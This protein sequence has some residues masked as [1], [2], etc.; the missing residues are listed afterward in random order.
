GRLLWCGTHH[1]T[2]PGHSLLDE[3]HR[4]QRQRLHLDPRQVH[5]LASM[6]DVNTDKTPGLIKVQHDSRA[7]L[8]GLDTRPIRKVYVE[9]VGL[10]IVVESHRCS[11][12]FAPA[13]SAK[14]RSKNALWTVSPSSSVT[15]RR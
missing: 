1:S 3:R 12:P 14:P 15:T 5:V 4:L 6:L 2:L 10:A 7:Y 9:R 8:L 13:G 11:F